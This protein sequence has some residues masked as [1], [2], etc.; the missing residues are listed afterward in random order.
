MNPEDK[1]RIVDALRSGRYQQGR[2]YLRPSD[3]RFCC[4]GVMCDVLKDEMDGE[5]ERVSTVWHFKD[6]SQPYSRHDTH[7]PDSLVFRLGLSGV[8]SN[9]MQMNDGG[10]TF[11]EI[12]DYLEKNL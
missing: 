4:L 10:L 12:A 5:W 11:T 2:G 1:T 9:L 7:L 3:N 8:Q 6:K